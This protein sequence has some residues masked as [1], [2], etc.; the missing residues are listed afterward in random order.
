M[1]EICRNIVRHADRF[2]FESCDPSVVPL[3]RIS[4]ATV[5]TIYCAVWMRDSQLWFTDNGVLTTSTAQLINGHRQWSLLFLL[6]ST[7]GV[8]HGCLTVMFVQCLLMLIGCWSRFQVAC[9]F[10][11]LVSFQHRNQLICDGEDTLFRLMSFLLIFLPLDARWSLLRWIFKK[12]GVPITTAKSWGLRL[13]QIQMSV[14]YASAGFNKLLGV[15]W[16]DGTALYYV[17][18]MTD[19]FG[20]LPLPDL[21]FE[22]LWVVQLQTW[23]VVLI[24]LALP[25]AL[26]IRPTRRMALVLGFGLH[27][28]IEATMHLFLFQWIMMV[29]LLSFVTFESKDSSTG[30]DPKSGRSNC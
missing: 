27:L 30:V 2:F 8:V 24:E 17:S 21:L 28:A 11:W 7:A 13:I 23:M 4:F 22:K 20:R 1:R 19:H 29:G 15:T 12:P 14:I 25:I 5:T 18:R 9:I 10:V 26:W 16:R 3:L 6:P